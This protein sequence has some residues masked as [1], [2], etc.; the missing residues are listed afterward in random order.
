MA[1]TRGQPGLALCPLYPF[2]YFYRP[3]LLSVNLN[4]SLF[5]IDP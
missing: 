1:R 4:F 5:L 2:D 3:F